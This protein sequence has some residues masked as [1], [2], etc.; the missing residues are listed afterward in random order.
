L[1]SV[2]EIFTRRWSLVACLA[3]AFAALV[4]LTLGFVALFG[5]FPR[6]S[7]YAGSLLAGY[8]MVH[9]NWRLAGWWLPTDP[10]W[11]TDLPIYGFASLV[12]G[13]SAATLLYV[14]AALWAGLTVAACATALA[15]AHPGGRLRAT[16][17]VLTLMALP[18]FRTSGVMVQIAH[19]PMHVA[20]LLLVLAMF[21]LG[22]RALA[23]SPRRPRARSRH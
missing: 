11:T 10:F 12:F 21:A 1:P 6:G 2:A 18:L 8:D 19:A 7:D 4:V 20:S 22:A 16:G 9:G 23:G 15:M 13:L 3:V 17:T 5:Q 14:P